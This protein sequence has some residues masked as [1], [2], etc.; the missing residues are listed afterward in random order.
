MHN[1][2]VV[3]TCVLELVTCIVVLLCVCVVEYCGGSDIFPNM[4]LH[5]GA[6][7]RTLQHIHGKHTTLNTKT[8]LGTHF[9]RKQNSFFVKHLADK[10]WEYRIYL[11]D[12]CTL[13]S[14]ST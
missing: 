13:N 10:C 3:L 12:H 14:S 9:L 7:H 11:V 1:M 5:L 6:I 4:I 8:H 2:C